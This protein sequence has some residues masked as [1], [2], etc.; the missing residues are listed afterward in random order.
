MNK[1]VVTLS[2]VITMV[3]AFSFRRAINRSSVPVV[4]TRAVVYKNKMLAYCSPDWSV[5]NA[6]SLANFISPLPGWGN[7]HWKIATSQDSAQFYF[8][9]GINMYYAFHIIEAMA[10]FKK[11]EQFDANNCMI[12]WAQALAY[13]P[14]INDYEYKAFNDALSNARKAKQFSKRATPKEQALINAMLTRYSADTTISRVT[15]NGLY[16]AE[17]KTAYQTFSNDPDVSTLYADA[18]LVQH[19]WEYWKHNGMPQPW[20]PEILS[21]LEHTLKLLP[22]HPGANHYYIHATEASPNPARA[23]AS[24]DRLGTL[25]SGVSHMIHM[26]SHIYIR[27]GNYD[28]GVKV[29]EMSVSGYQ[30]YR[31]LYPAVESNAPLYLI[32]N[33][34]MQA[35]CAMFRSNYAYSLQS[36]R[37]AAAT[38]DTSF[39]SMPQPFGNFVQY[40]YLTPIMVN[41][42]YGKYNEVLQ[43]EPLPANYVYANALINWAKG[44]AYANTSDITKAKHQLASLQKIMQHNDLKIVMTP[45]NS[46]LDA[47]KVAEKLLEGSI[48]EK[49]GES[50]R[51]IASYR[52]AVLFEDA[53]IYNEPR[54]WLIPTRH[55]L[56]NGL[57]KNKEYIAAYQVLQQDLHQN[58]AN[59][60]ALSGMVTLL[61]KLG[62]KTE[63]IKYERQLKK[64]FVYADTKEPQLI[65]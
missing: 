51:A 50:A 37:D 55:Y 32:H 58:P 18:L 20:T 10:S 24:A 41:V 44:M 3:A 35:A 65:Y 39:M 34:H 46:A 1:K 49:T 13:G 22:N 53:L 4:I 25:M 52:Q 16:A 63:Q 19:P 9:Q 38:F 12:F 56:A 15:L 42:R 43:Q 47:L 26:P 45:F 28:K 31:K 7:Y 33:L 5:I 11:A 2:I 61:G 17:M 36:A 64:A 21:V 57:I 60:Y 27:T 54:D 29:N 59:F 48:Y 30:Q 8:N 23:I 14:N 62:K 40:V 6:D